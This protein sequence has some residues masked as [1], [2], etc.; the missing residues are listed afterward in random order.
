MLWAATAA[1]YLLFRFW[2]DSRSGP[3]SPEE[4]EG[5][6]ADLHDRLEETGND[7]EVLRTF[8]G[9]DDGREFLM[10]NL[11]KVQPEIVTDPGSGQPIPGSALFRRYA[12]RFMPVLLRH[13]GHPVMI[14]RK[15]GGY[16]DAW[17][18][19]PDPGWTVSGLMRYR[20]RRDFMNLVRD[21]A[22]TAA[23]PEKILGTL[24]TFSFPAQSMVMLSPGPR[25]T[26]AL[27][28]A[29]VAALVH[30]ALVTG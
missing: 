2:Y 11:V 3:L 23:H 13:G 18:V 15:V 26:V 7:V 19:A 24:A 28:L 6:L 27:V 5:A 22:F 4:I 21:P 9:T 25:I 12:R 20:S 16:L 17:N 29:L 14:G 30:L 8:L 10:V 1:I